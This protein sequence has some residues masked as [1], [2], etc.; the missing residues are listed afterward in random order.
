M[1]SNPGTSEAVHVAHED[2]VHLGTTVVHALAEATGTDPIDME[3]ELNEVVDPDALH[4]LFAAR[5]DGTPRRGG[6]VTF[7]ILDHTVRIG[8]DDSGGVVVSV[9]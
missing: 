7:D 2:G 4:R 6:S 9:E 5:S 3:V 8:A 1:A